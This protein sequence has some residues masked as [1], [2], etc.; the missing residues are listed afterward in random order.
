[1]KKELP[2]NGQPFIRALPQYAFLD[3][4]VN[5][6]NTNT[7]EVYSMKIKGFHAEEWHFTKH[8][9][10]IWTKDETIHVYRKGFGIESLAGWYCN[11]QKS[12]EIVFELTYMQYTN[13]WDGMTFFIDRHVN[14]LLDEEQPV[15]YKFIVHCCGDL[16]VDVGKDTVF[17]KSNR[18]NKDIPRLYKVKID[19]SRISLYASWDY[20]QK[21]G[22]LHETISEIPLM[23]TKQGF[24]VRLCENQYFKWICNNFQLIRYERDAGEIVNYTGFLRRDWKNYTVHPLVKFSYDKREMIKR[25]GLWEY[26][27]ASIDNGRYME[28]WLNEYFINGTAA[29]Q[30]YSYNHENLIYGYDE[31]SRKVKMM[32]LYNGKPILTE[33]PIDIIDTAWQNAYE[34]NAEIKGFEFAPDE[35]GY[36]LDLVHI[37]EQM[38]DYL[39][40]RDCSEDYQYLAEREKGIFGICIYGEILNHEHDKEKFLKDARAA[41]QIKEHKECMRFKFRYLHEGG[42]LPDKEYL[43]L[44]EQ[45]DKVV[46]TADILLNMVLKNRIAER[47]EIQEKIWEY[48]ECL[49]KCDRSC[50]QFFLHILEVM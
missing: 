1:M 11:M 35:G 21:W 10:D 26:V 44:M 45:A 18:E 42:I 38:Q 33:A 27:T 31:S 36:E 17:Y 4:I 41:Y 29:Y 46:A 24:C 9:T 40:G 16:R 14:F 25:C 34:N 15:D 2:I 22:L 43:L 12:G 39:N 28:V 47:T 23:G 30:S 7:D 48:L 3:A 8:C 19:S 37:Y 49:E 50:C 20:G 5:N 13:R 6:Y 32:S